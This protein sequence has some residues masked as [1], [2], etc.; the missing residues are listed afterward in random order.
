MDIKIAYTPPKEVIPI[1][2]QVL[3]L[4][5]TLPDTG[6]KVVSGREILPFNFRYDEGEKSGYLN[7]VLDGM[8]NQKIN[9]LWMG[10]QFTIPITK[11][12]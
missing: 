7:I 8:P 3:L 2:Q 5:I 9:Y 12:F 10:E 6:E 4:N 11:P 1:Y